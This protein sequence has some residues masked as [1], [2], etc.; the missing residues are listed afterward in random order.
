MS[1]ERSLMLEMPPER[2]DDTV[3]SMARYQSSLDDHCA[4]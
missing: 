4:R 1:L 2:M 3:L